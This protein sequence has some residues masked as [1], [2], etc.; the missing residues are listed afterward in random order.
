MTGSAL[1][2]FLITLIVIVAIG[3]LFYVAIGAIS[4]NETFVKI[5]RIAVGV[6]LLIIFLLAVRGVFFG[7]GGAARVSPQGVLYFAAA[8]IVALLVIF[9]VKWFVGWIAPEFSEPVI[10]VISA[11]ALIALLY[12]AGEIL[13]GGGL[14]GV[15]RPMIAR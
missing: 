14:A 6:S 15:V 7:G 11:I 5:A 13:F 9:L 1:F 4:T 2:D 10:F 8:I 3:S 12:V